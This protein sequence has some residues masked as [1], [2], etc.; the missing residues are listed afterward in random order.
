MHDE[1]DV[2]GYNYRTK[3]CFLRKQLKPKPLFGLKLL[4]AT[5]QDFFEIM[6]WYHKKYGGLRKILALVRDLNNLPARFVFSGYGHWLRVLT[7]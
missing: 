5:K 7:Q 2:D 3:R 4:A 6:V 1:N